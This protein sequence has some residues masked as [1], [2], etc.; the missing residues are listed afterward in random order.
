MATQDSNENAQDFA[1][2]A[3]S[4]A[5]DDDERNSTSDIQ[6]HDFTES[7]G[8]TTQDRLDSEGNY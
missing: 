4:I 8:F 1:Y 5:V 6:L 2:A 3:E 7:A